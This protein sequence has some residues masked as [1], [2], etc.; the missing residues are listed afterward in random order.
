MN[1]DYLFLCFF[2]E[3]KLYENEII[4]ISKKLTKLQNMNDLSL[5]NEFLLFNNNNNENNANQS[6]INSNNQSIIHLNDSMSDSNTNDYDYV[7]YMNM[8]EEKNSF[9]TH[10]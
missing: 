1:F 8:N 9:I 6:I 7:S 10:K 2:S 4:I 5:L 3:I